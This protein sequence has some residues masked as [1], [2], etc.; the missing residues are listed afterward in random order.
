[1]SRPTRIALIAGGVY[2][3]AWGAYVLKSAANVDL[4]A[5]DAPVVGGHHG[6]MFPGS[7]RVVA[8]LKRR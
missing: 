2:A 5:M 7:D 6:W 8:W 4:V 1:M 3:F